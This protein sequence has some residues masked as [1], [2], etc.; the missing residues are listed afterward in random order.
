MSAPTRL[1]KIVIP[2][3]L[4]LLLPL[5]V[6]AGTVAWVA[7]G[8]GDWNNP[9]NWSTGTLPQAGDDVI[10]NP[11]R[12]VTVTHGSGDTPLN[13]LNL[14]GNLLL[15]GGVLSV[16]AASQIT[17]DLTVSNGATLKAIGPA[18]TFTVS[19][20]V[21]LDAA[22]VYAL[23]GGRITL[24]GAIY[25]RGPG[26]LRAQGSGS[27]LELPN[28]GSIGLDAPGPVDAVITGAISREV[29]VYR[30][31]EDPTINGAV[32]REVS[33]YRSAEDP[34]ALTIQGAV[35]REVSVYRQVGAPSP[36]DPALGIG[37][38]VSR[39][40]SVY[41]QVG[42]PSP[43]DPTLGIGGAVSRETSVENQVPPP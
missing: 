19:G 31:A 23:D 26:I 28:L 37:G 27:R 11:G 15:T 13:S 38:A 42:A 20:A 4:V 3:V 5:A 34:M 32:S 10:V 2:A 17:G 9:A 8:D 43:D 30:A 39:E 6:Q 24:P 18:A 36:D 41:R 40:V 1:I 29:S 25:Y 21:T 22:N 14:T 16:T 35:S 12:S 33:V 7:A